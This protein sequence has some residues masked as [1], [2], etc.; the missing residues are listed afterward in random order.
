M[1][2][3]AKGLLRGS[4]FMRCL[5]WLDVVLKSEE[6]PNRKSRCPL[7]MLTGF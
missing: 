3:V 7:D 1:T 2:E 4:I 6:E 5:G